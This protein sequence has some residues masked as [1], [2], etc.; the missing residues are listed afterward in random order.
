[1]KP[2]TRLTKCLLLLPLASV[3]VLP[4]LHAWAAAEPGPASHEPTGTLT[5][6]RACASALVG[7]PALHAFS[8]D[9]RASEARVLQAGL[10]PNP[11]VDLEVEDFG[12][13]GGFSGGQ[14][15]QTTLQ[16]SQVIELGGKHSARRNAAAAAR[17]LTT[18]EYELNR[19]EVLADVAEKFIALLAAQHEVT[20]TRETTQLAHAALRAVRERLRA[21]KASALQEKTALVALARHR[22]LEEHAQYELATARAQLAATW[23]STTPTFDHAEGA[24][25]DLATVP[26]FEALAAQVA[27]SPEITRWASAQQLRAA[28][29]RLARARRIPNLTIG[30]GIRRLEG[31][32]VEAFVA[33]LT[34]PL[35][36]FDRNQGQ[37]AE[38]EA[39][40]HATAANQRGAAIRLQTVLF[41]L[42]Q[43]LRHAATALE[44]LENEILPQASAALALSEQGFGQGRFSYLGFADAQ[45]TFIDVRRERVQVAANYQQLLLGIE[46]LIGQP[47][48]NTSPFQD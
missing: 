4:R 18:R 5:L 25:F 47:I 17:D 24:L 32:D 33:G 42:H 23:G 7:S 41:G 36:I 19:V 16:L 35:P 30:G 22:I 27:A 26:P 13:T 15:A 1:M 34:I 46:R 40:Q 6:S 10:R 37:L 9:L 44:S 45:R 39:L 21:G 48:H 31:P 11:T 3:L 38:A 8:W 43:E 14:K 2:T 28:E 20:L 29:V 12:G